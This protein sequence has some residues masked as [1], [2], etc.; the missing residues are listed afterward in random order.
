MDRNERLLEAYSKLNE[1]WGLIDWAKDIVGC[2]DQMRQII[3][4]SRRVLSDTMHV[5]YKEIDPSYLDD[6]E[7]TRRGLYGLA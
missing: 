4:E 7:E 1:A 2:D 3:L 5:V 6:K